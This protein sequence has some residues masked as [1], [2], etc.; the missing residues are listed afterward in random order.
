MKKILFASAALA[1]ALV[2]VPAAASGVSYTGSLDKNSVAP[3]GTVSYTS[4]DTGQPSG[5]PA[6]VSATPDVNY[7]GSANVG[8]YTVAADGSLHFSFT[9]P[10][11]AANGTVFTISVTAGRFTDSK[12]VTAVVASSSGLPATGVDAAPYIW[13]GGGAVALGLAIVVVV[14]VTR[15]NRKPSISQA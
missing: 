7:I 8:H 2:T 11:S 5:T 4:T 14:A 13:F 15:R 12:T 10:T 9:L 1:L 6:D 3:G